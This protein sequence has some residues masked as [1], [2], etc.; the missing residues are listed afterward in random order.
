M[1]TVQVRSN[2]S[3][4]VQKT[5]AG[6]AAKLGL[7]LPAYIRIVLGEKALQLRLLKRAEEMAG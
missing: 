2:I 6:E 7:E 4:D 1:K 3:I 5:L